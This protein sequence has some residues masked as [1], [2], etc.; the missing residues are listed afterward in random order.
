MSSG[1]LILDNNVFRRL[2]SPDA[3]ARLRANIR[4]A[5]LVVH[6]TE[7]NLLEITAAPAPIRVRLLD[8][9]RAVSGGQPLVPWPLQLLQG[10]GRALLAGEPTYSPGPSGKE[11]YLED[12][13]ALGAIHEEVRRFNGALER[14]F[15]E[16]HERSRQRIDEQVRPKLKALGLK[17]EFG[18]A[19]AFLDRYWAGS[20]ER[21]V[22]AEVT[23]DALHLPGPAPIAQL[24]RV[25]AWRLLLD[26]EGVGAYE[27]AIAHEQPKRVGRLDLLQ[28]VY[29][30]G[31]RRR[32]LST[33][34]AGLLR[35]GEAI[36]PG[37][38]ANARV[39]PTS[40]ILA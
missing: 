36:L 21:R 13:E 23:W 7:V 16:F 10:I 26:A 15:T 5:D 8:A 33:A 31:A 18:S 9:R 32:I 24:E 14:D 4:A 22:Y 28:L 20:E 2:E 38:Y 27:R 17:D 30:A 29:L 25:D 19:R 3:F 37:R 34:D 12:P 40:V 35:A 11:W 6:P 39:V 1:L